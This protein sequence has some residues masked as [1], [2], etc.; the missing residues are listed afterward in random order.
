MTMKGVRPYQ[1]R[2]VSSHSKQNGVALLMVLWSIALL[3]LLL[4]QLVG[5]VRLE[6]KLARLR[7]DR[8]RAELSAQGGIA[9]AVAALSN[10]QMNRRWIADGRPYTT[11][12]DNDIHLETRIWSEKGKID[13]NAAPANTL[14]R[15]F[16]CA[17]D[18]AAHATRVADEVQDW[19]E[20]GELARAQ[21]AKTAAYRAAGRRDGPREAPMQ[22]PEELEQ[23]LAM[24]PALFE[25]V[26]G[27]VTV[28]SGNADIDTNLA[29]PLAL[30]AA[31]G[32]APE[33]A[34]AALQEKWRGDGN[35]NA[36]SDAGPL[37]NIVSEA[38]LPNG[39]HATVSA[40][41]L[42]RDGDS[43]AANALPYMILDWKET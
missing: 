40:V 8:T 4:V 38:T 3:S 35:T 39:A 18:S 13:L 43:A 5:D 24:S 27:A 32:V 2:R 30:C 14:K 16:V 25:V 22:H 11:V 26:S 17:G 31:H 7:L 34:R 36:A 19:R 9:T 15:L 42:L 21:G 20:P 29:S 41:L 12:V 1:Q 33:Q 23:V 37:V 28:W 6:S 10:V